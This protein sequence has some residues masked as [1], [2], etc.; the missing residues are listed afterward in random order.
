MAWLGSCVGASL[1]AIAVWQSM[2]L[3][4]V[5]PPSRAGSLPQVFMA[6]IGRWSGVDPMWER[7]CS[8]RRCSGWL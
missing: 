4:T 3:L 7:A 5:R 8:R 6:F 2:Q 1:L